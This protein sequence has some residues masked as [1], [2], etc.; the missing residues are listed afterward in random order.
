MSEEKQEFERTADIIEHLRQ[1]EERCFHD[2]ES[3]IVI[4]TDVEAD[5]PY[6]YTILD[7]KVSSA[8]EILGWIQHLLEKTWMEPELLERFIQVA[9]DVGDVE[10]SYP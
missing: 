10:I 8:E 4:V 6:T 5:E 1:V 9:A 3:H 2:G 7:S